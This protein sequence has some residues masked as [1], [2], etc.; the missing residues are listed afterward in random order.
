[1]NLFYLIDG[2]SGKTTFL[3]AHDLK[4]TVRVEQ[5]S[6]TQNLEDFSKYINDYQVET[7]G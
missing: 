3:K 1:M 2:G 4:S 7:Q 5:D 6:S